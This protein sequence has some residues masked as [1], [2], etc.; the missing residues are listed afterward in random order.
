MEKSWVNILLELQEVPGAR[1]MSRL[2]VLVS[3][4]NPHMEGHMKG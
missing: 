1:T 4:E 3:A 2:E